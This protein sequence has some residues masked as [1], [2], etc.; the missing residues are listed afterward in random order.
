MI[1]EITKIHNNKSTIYLL[2]IS[3]I[4]HLEPGDYLTDLE[5]ENYLSFSSLKRKREYFATRYLRHLIFG[6]E[7]IH[8]DANGAPYVNDDIYISISHSKNYVALACNE[9]YQVGL[10]LE[11]PKDKI[12]KLYTKFM[13]SQEIESVADLNSTVLTKFWSGKEALYKLANRNGILFKEE[14]YLKQV[15]SISWRGKIENPDGWI[16]VYLDIFEWNGLIVS[17]NNDMIH[18]HSR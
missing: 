16:D 12:L 6:F 10:D 14:L 4:V 15:N 11:D 18:E 1:P 7:H 17:I 2:E 8:Y 5:L 9:H 13:S 3:Q